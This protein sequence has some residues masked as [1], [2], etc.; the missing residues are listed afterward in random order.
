YISDRGSEDGD[1]DVW[2]ASL[3]P[4]GGTRA[5]AEGTRIRRD[6]HS[7]AWSPAGSLIA[8][9]GVRNGVSG[10]WVTSID[11]GARPADGPVL[12]SRTGR[13]P[14]WSPDG[15]RIAIADVPSIEPA[16]NGNPLRNQDDA[17]PLFSESYH[18]RFVDAPL[19]VDSGAR[20]HR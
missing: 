14:A 13:T 1:V 2:V 20:N 17:P 9:F 18:L 8:F 4:A 12:V 15:R 11:P 3:S 5:H 7:P 6:A 19:P 16:Y 10:V